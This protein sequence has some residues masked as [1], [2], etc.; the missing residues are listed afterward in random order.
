MGELSLDR[1]LSPGR[2]LRKSALAGF[3]ALAFASMPFS[4]F[5][6]DEAFFYPDLHGGTLSPEGDLEEDAAV[7]RRMGRTETMMQ[8]WFDWK[9]QLRQDTGL[10]IGGSYGILAQRYSSSPAGQTSA[11]GH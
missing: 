4:A 6:Q 10:T 2:Y 7:A 1:S 3:C 11:I 5:A 9:Q 8:P